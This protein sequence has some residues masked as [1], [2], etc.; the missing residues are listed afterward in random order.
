MWFRLDLFQTEALK[1]M[2]SYNRNK[3]E[4]D[5][6]EMMLEIIFLEAFGTSASKEDTSNGME[7]K[8]DI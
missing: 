8:Q 5:L 1:R 7:P 4:C 6:R 2:I 3:T